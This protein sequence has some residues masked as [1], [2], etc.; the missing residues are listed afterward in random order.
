MVHS[1]F[2]SEFYCWFLLSQYS[3]YYSGQ[4][5]VKI[6]VLDPQASK[7]LVFSLLKT[8]NFVQHSTSQLFFMSPSLAFLLLLGLAMNLFHLEKKFPKGSYIKF[9]VVQ[10]CFTMVGSR[11][12]IQ[13]LF[14]SLPL[15]FQCQEHM[16]GKWPANLHMW[17]T[18]AAGVQAVLWAGGAVQWDTTLEAKPMPACVPAK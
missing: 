3:Y 5:K 10:V 1:H 9:I 14:F 12:W 4:T 17:V 7:A 6:E 15:F 13:L 11:I 2:L 18:I 16:G 8:Y